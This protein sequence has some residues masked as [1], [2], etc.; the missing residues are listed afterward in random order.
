MEYRTHRNEEL[1]E[2]GVGCYALAGAYGKVDPVLF[3]SV[4][5]RAYVLGVTFFDTAD[6]YGP[7]KEILGRAVASFRDRVWIAT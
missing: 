5:R 6:V 4:L 1:S 7:A 3:V 2:I